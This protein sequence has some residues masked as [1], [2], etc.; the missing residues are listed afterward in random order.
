[1]AP[2]G[3]DP[4][5]GRA[6][7]DGT[8]L[9][10]GRADRRET[11]GLDF[12]EV[13]L[14]QDGNALVVWEH[15]Q[16]AE[17]GSGVSAVR[18]SALNSP[19]RGG[20][21][22]RSLTLTSSG[23]IGAATKDDLLTNTKRI[24]ASLLLAG[25]LLVGFASPGLASL[26]TNTRHSLGLG[27]DTYAL[28]EAIADNPER[29]FGFG[30]VSNRVVTGWASQEFDTSAFWAA[31]VDSAHVR[32]TVKDVTSCFWF[33]TQYHQEIVVTL[34]S[35]AKGGVRHQLSS[36]QYSVIPASWQSDYS[37]L[38]SDGGELETELLRQV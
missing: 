31:G 1:M 26:I 11:L 20:Q 18:Y 12:P 33:C 19:A 30:T 4:H 28:A 32:M 9:E 17:P 3:R 35:G 2:T 14:D 25:A 6:R 34:L 22:L 24:L 23:P 10:R 37:T 29:M 21:V 5:R 7:T 36:Q 27:V 13:V 8:R 38:E 15:S 16:G